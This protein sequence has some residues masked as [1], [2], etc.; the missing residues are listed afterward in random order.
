MYS[1]HGK[2]GGLKKIQCGSQKTG[3]SRIIRFVLFHFGAYLLIENY[4]SMYGF[5]SSSIFC[6]SAINF[7][8]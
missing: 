3:Q 1:A 2:P 6:L 4:T 8:A 7:L 5:I